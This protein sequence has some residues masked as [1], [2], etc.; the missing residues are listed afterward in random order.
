MPLH[1]LFKRLAVGAWQV[2]QYGI[3]CIEPEEIAMAPDRRTRAAIS[4]A[5][6][7]VEAGPRTS[8]QCMRGRAFPEILGLCRYVVQHPVYPCPLRSGRIGRIRIGH[9]QH[10]ASG[11]GRAVRPVGRDGLR[12]AASLKGARMPWADI[13]AAAGTFADALGVGVLDDASE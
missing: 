7:V 13:V 8:R 5:L 1:R 9:D 12:G 2:P 4:A 10:I 11:A 3:Q 6:P